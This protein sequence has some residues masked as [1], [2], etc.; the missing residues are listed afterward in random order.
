MKTMHISQPKIA[1]LVCRSLG[2]GGWL[3]A[4]EG[5]LTQPGAEPSTQVLHAPRALKVHVAGQSLGASMSIFM[6]F[7]T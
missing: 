7:G 4:R 3:R 1:G 5:S 6:N 2:L